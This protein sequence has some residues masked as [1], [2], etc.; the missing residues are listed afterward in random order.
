MSPPPSQVSLLL[1]GV[2]TQLYGSPDGKSKQGTPI[3]VLYADERVTALLTVYNSPLFCLYPCAALNCNSLSQA[4][5]FERA[6]L[7]AAI[8]VLFY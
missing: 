6:H 4:W 5:G 2:R 8:D 1:V 7:S 3:E